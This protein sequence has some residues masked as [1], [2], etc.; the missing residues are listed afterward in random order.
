MESIEV[1]APSTSKSSVAVM[2]KAQ[3]IH[4]DCEHSSLSSQ[5]RTKEKKGKQAFHSSIFHLLQSIYN[6]NL[7]QL[8]H[9]LYPSVN[10]VRDFAEA[11]DSF[12]VLEEYFLIFV[13]ASDF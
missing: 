4:F 10:V 8:Q 13:T 12:Q 5:Q 6:W 9:C 11:D 7:F 1:W 2:A 3:S